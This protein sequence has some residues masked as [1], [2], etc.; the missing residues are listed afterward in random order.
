MKKCEACKN[1]FHCFTLGDKERSGC[2]VEYVL[3]ET[4]YKMNRN[5]NKIYRDGT[6]WTI[7]GTARDW[8]Y[9][10]GYEQV[11]NTNTYR[12]RNGAVQKRRGLIKSGEY[13]D[14]EIMI[15]KL[16]VLPDRGLDK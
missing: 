2:P 11:P 8:H 1:R 5:G 14:G 6:E 9:E 3:I 15:A 10:W 13:T 16:E 4:G 7:S 12:T